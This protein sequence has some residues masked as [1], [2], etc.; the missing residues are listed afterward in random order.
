MALRY[1]ASGKSDK[2]RVRSS[3]QD[4]GYAGNNLFIVADGM[5]GHAGGDIASAIATQH[6]AKAEDVYPTVL[7]AEAALTKA[8]T[9]A[10]EELKKTVESFKYLEGMG[11]TMDALIFTG[12]AATILHIGDSRVYYLKDQV[13]SQVT[14]DH[15]FVQKLIDAGRITE[16]EALYHP[17]RNVLMRVLGDDSQDIQFDV[18]QLEAA[19]GD[20]FLLCSD[21]LCSYVP[22]A[23][24]AENM[25]VANLDEATDLL[26]AEALEFGAP[27]NVTVILVEVREVAED[28]QPQG[29]TWLGSAANEVVINEVGSNRFLQIFNRLSFWEAFRKREEFISESDPEFQKVL[30]EFDGRVRSWKLR[31]LAL[32]LLIGGLLFGSIFGFYSYTQTRFYLGVENGKVAIYQGIKESFAGVGFSKLYEES[33]I[34]VTDL[35]DFQKDLLERTI[36]ADSLDDAR[37]KLKQIL[38]SITNG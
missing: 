1:V 12:D 14:K 13:F 35:P 15:T 37:A 25:K 3:N 7:K 9:E 33:S 27:D 20:R 6:V 5:G 26:I 16:E 2:G 34:L 4:S 24:I 36:S 21:G 11:T 22:E 38:E 23:I 29:I 17:R 31:G 32:F 10:N 8:M 30:S 19:P 18:H 28:V